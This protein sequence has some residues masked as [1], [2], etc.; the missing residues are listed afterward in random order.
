VILKTF[1]DY[2]FHLGTNFSKAFFGCLSSLFSEFFFLV[3][4]TTNLPGG[5][6]L[7]ER[8]FAFSSDSLH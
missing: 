1:S 8:D 7:V 6:R 3:I 5:R 4:F 2:F